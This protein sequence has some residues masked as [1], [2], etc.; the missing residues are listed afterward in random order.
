MRR[1]FSSSLAVVLA[2]GR[3]ILEEEAS[4]RALYVVI[5]MGACAAAVWWLKSTTGV[6]CPWSVEPFGGAL[7]MTDPA[8][9]LTDV[10][11]R[12]WPS[13][14][15]GTGFVFIAFYFALKDVRPRAAAGALL[16]A[17]AFGLLCGAVRV[18]EGAHFVSHVLVTGI[19]DWLICAAL[20][21]LILED[22]SSPAFAKPLS[23]RGLVLLTAF[24]WTFVLNMPFLARAADLSEPNFAWSMREALT[25]AGLSFGLLFISIALLTLVMALPRPVRRA[26]LV[27]LSLT[28]AIF[29]AGTLVYGIAFDPNMARNVISTDVHEASAYFSAR[30]L[31]LAL[32]AGLPPVLAA[33]AADM[34]P[35]G[36]RP[37]AVRGGVAILALAAGAARAIHADEHAC[38]RHAKRQGA[39]LPPITPVNV[40]YSLATTLA[41]DASPDAAQ[42]RIVDPKPEFSVRLSRPAVLLV[43]IGETTRSASWGLAGY[44]RDTTPALRAEGVISHPSVTACGSSYRRFASLH[45]EQDRPLRLRP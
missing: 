30:T 6:A 8:F 5:A 44:A 2:Q 4:R 29:F 41:R 11:G 21:A 35:A 38:G 12:C 43:V 18:M 7:P 13:G 39:A 19:V 37:A 36:L 22:R 34:T 26:V 32:A 45:A 24:W 27:L 42:K 20:H 3:R 9:G 31:L 15:A 17:V 40:P 10:P 1:C 28:G 33:S 23:E 16:F 14:H 25:L